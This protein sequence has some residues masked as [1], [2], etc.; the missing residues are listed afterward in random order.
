MNNWAV[1][2]G[3]GTGIGQAL[4]VRLARHMPVLIVGRTLQ[5]LQQ[6]QRLAPNGNIHVCVADVSREEDMAVIEA[7]LPQDATLQF[8]VHNAAVLSPKPLLEVT[9]AEWKQQMDINV[10]ASLTLTQT[11]I[12]KLQ[13]AAAAALSPRILHISSGAAHRS[14]AGWGGYCVSKAALFMLYRCL[15]AE[16]QPLGIAVGSAKPGVVD[17]PMQAEIR[18][19]SEEK[20]SEV[21]YFRRLKEEGQLLSADETATFLEYLLRETTAEQFSADEWDVRNAEHHHL[22]KHKV[23]A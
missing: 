20:F 14:V 4:A 17:T 9:A 16:L 13:R 12:A 8:L 11:L 7:A 19:L 22:W 2:T 1:I 10:T 5:T 3:A 21:N 18:Q 23:Q 15:A 6:T